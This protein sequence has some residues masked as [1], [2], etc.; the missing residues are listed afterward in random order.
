MDGRTETKWVAKESKNRQ[1]VVEIHDSTHPEETWHI[2]RRAII[3]NNKI[4][5][6]FKSI[7]WL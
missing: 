1:K 7:S 2:K 4:H 6:H 3:S 5:W